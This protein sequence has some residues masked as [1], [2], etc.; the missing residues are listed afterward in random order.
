MKL[1]SLMSFA[2]GVVASLALSTMAHAAVLGVY[3]IKI[4]NKAGEGQWLQVNE[5]IAISSLTGTDV[6][7]TSAGATATATAPWN[8][9]YAAE[10]AID[11]LV[12]TTNN[13]FYHGNN[14]YNSFLN[15]SLAGPT[16]LDS[17]TIVGRLTCCQNR[18]SYFVELLDMSGALL[19]SGDV[20]ARNVGASGTTLDFR[21]AAVPLPA[22]SVLLLTGLFGAA[23]L[24]RLK[25]R[26]A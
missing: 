25:K 19:F 2:T 17:L 6:A 13:S 3:D 15:I 20:D 1:R 11:G 21:M 23:A 9:N 24:K 18:D 5:V 4:T 16:D 26:A 7:L 14:R 10:K 12:T 22:G 8:A